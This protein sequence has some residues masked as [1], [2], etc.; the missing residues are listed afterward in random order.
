MF[1][2]FEPYNF[3]FILLLLNTCGSKII[4]PLHAIIKLVRI[5][6]LGKNIQFVGVLKG[7]PGK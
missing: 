4:F 6:I 2:F 1:K 7:I 5:P 3:D